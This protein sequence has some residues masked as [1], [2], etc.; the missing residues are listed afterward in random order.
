MRTITSCPT[1]RVE[2]LLELLDKTSFDAAGFD[3][4]YGRLMLWEQ[5]DPVRYWFA[6]AEFDE[7]T[8]AWTKGVMKSIHRMI[9]RD[10]SIRILET[11]VLTEADIAIF[12]LSRDYVVF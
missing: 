5:P 10:A 3:R 4:G 2:G 12:C 6:A 8:F 7:E 11:T 1:P 9:G